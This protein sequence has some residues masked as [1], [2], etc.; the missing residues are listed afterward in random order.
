MVIRMRSVTA[1]AMGIGAL[2][3]VGGCRTQNGDY[4][5]DRGQVSGQPHPNNSGVAPDSGSSSDPSQQ[6]PAG[7]GADTWRP[8]DRNNP[9]EPYGS[10]MPAR[11]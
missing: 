5:R 9:P 10:G 8:S 4:N 3:L 6:A 2:L 11:R 7:G 1:V